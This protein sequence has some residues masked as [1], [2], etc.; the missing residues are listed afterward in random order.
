MVPPSDCSA[1]PTAARLVGNIYQPWNNVSAARSRCRSTMSGDPN[2]SVL[3][4]VC[5]KRATC[6]SSMLQED[7]GASV[8]CRPVWSGNN[9]SKARALAA[10]GRVGFFRYPGS[11]FSVF[12]AR[13]QEFFSTA[14]GKT[15]P[16]APITRPAFI[17]QTLFPKRSSPL[18][19]RTA[20]PFSV[21]THPYQPPPPRSAY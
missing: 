14:A 4:A 9:P 13:V 8:G 16:I 19:N 7:T 12:C 20:P 21:T 2:A 5:S 6:F 1:S 11:R 3:V 10:S 18:V 17:R 15:S